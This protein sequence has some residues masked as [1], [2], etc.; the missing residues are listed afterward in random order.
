M[1]FCEKL[2]ALRK[3]SGLSQEELGLELG[4]SR[5]TVSKWEAGQS[6]PD[7]HRLVLLSDYFGLSLDELVR[8][9]DV[10]DVRARS[11]ADK[12][13]ASLHGDA[14][15]AKS[16]LRR[17]VRV[18]AYGA[19]ALAGLVLAGFLVHVLFPEIPFLWVVG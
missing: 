10:Q 5:Q 6:Y 9:L 3:Q 11:L 15:R 17:G 8:G 16:L 18:L 4:V 2:L 14:E 13:I 19:L 7:F 1:K 12:Q